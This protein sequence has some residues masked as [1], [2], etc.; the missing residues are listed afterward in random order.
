MTGIRKSIDNNRRRIIPALLVLVVLTAVT[1]PLALSPAWAAPAGVPDR[2]LSYGI[3]RL[4]WDSAASIRPDGSAELSLFSAN[5]PNVAS[6][7]GGKV[8]APG[9]NGHNTIRLKNNSGGMIQYT[10]VLYAIKSSP[11]IP[12]TPTL[13]GAYLTDTTRYLLPAGVDSSNVLRAVSGSVSAFGLQDFD[14]D[15]LWN[16][17]VGDA[18]DGV[19]TAIGNA[20][21][22]AFD[23]EIGEIDNIVV[24][25]YIVVEDNNTYYYPKT[26]D[27]AP[28]ELYAGLMIVAAVGVVGTAAVYKKRRHN[29]Q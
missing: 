19:D 26:G 17:Y 24:G 18:Q 13:S 1:L 25:L 15:W 20:A 22:R 5:Y 10:A 23:M 14:I 2:V 6:S 4:T 29:A 28:V 21:A 3:N 27:A 9:T 11:A 16:Y 12:V 8:I 7:D